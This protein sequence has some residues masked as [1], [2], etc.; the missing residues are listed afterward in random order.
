MRNVQNNERQICQDV[1]FNQV[2]VDAIT[3]IKTTTDVINQDDTTA[4]CEPW[5]AAQSPSI[6]AN[7]S[8]RATTAESLAPRNNCSW[9]HQGMHYHQSNH[10]AIYNYSCMQC[11]VTLIYK[12]TTSAESVT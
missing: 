7:V 9:C 5:F 6:V 11:W 8:R 4:A 2:H 10:E 12:Q 3:A 1:Q